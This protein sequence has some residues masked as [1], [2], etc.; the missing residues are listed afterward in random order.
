[1]RKF[2]FIQRSFKWRI[3]FANLQV[4]RLSVC[5]K[6]ELTAFRAPSEPEC[7][8]G[9]ALQYGILGLVSFFKR[10][11]IFCDSVD[12]PVYMLTHGSGGRGHVCSI[13]GGLL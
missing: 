1:M 2:L 4:K 5:G 6:I 11:P 13:A 9:C 10:K 8:A 3:G 7:I 12:R